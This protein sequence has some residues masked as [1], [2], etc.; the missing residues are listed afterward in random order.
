M[1]KLEILE[2]NNSQF[3]I[4]DYRDAKI[5]N[6]AITIGTGDAADRLLGVRFDGCEV[7]IKSSGRATGI[8][9]SQCHYDNCV[10]RASKIQK[11][12]RLEATFS[13]CSFIGKYEVGFY[14]DVT[15]C[16]FSKALLN[17]CLFFNI[18]D[19]SEC[20]WPSDGHLLISD[21]DDL[22][23]DDLKKLCIQAVTMPPNN[24]ALHLIRGPI[25]PRTR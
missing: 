2:P 5:R 9:L 11:I 17:Q 19:V 21:L 6:K 20:T 4:H 7:K 18:G 10:I 13:R 24:N 16:D 3:G 8:I 23:R 1:T 15:T 12:A 22:N 25:G 14:S